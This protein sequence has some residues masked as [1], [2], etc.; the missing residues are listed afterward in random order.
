MNL[1][2]L[3]AGKAAGRGT[4]LHVRP[5]F[6]LMLCYRGG[7]RLFRLR[8]YPQNLIRLIPAEEGYENYCTQSDSFVC[9]AAAAAA[10]ADAEVSST[11]DA[12]GLEAVKVTLDNGILFATGKYALQPAAQASLKKF[13]TNVLNVY[14]D[15]DV[16][17]Y[18]Y[19]SSDGS[20]ATNLTLSQNRANAVKNYL[21]GS[22]GVASSQIASTTGYGE[23][24]NYLIYDANGKENRPASRRVEIYLY[25]SAAM[26]EAANA[27]TLQ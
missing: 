10:L 26:I 8:L 27:G 18:G 13:A 15:C 25:A 16:A 19:A 21:T 2:K 9:T 14:T 7:G 11:T 22:C 23:D 12:N 5:A 1:P 24:P 17:I 3:S 6:S 20:D 4:G